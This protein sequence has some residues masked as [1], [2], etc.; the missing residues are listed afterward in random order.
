MKR[1]HK[2]KKIIEKRC[3]VCGK[4]F[5]KYARYKERGKVVPRRGY[6]TD[7]PRLRPILCITCSRE[8]SKSYIRISTHIRYKN[9]RR[10]KINS[11]KCNLSKIK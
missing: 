2:M 3:V 4:I 1:F 6:S 5:L 8:C 7:R 9:A 11:F 10:I